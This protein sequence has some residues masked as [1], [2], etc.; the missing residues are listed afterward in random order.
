LPQI[1]GE[2]KGKVTKITVRGGW[3][4]GAELCLC[5]RANRRSSYVLYCVRTRCCTL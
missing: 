5:C 4:S 3:E 2:S 1:D